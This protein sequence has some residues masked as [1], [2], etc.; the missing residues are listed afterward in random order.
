MD[1][2]EK[3]TI[4]IQEYNELK[5]E[6]KRLKSQVKEVEIISPEQIQIA[7][8]KTLLSVITKIRESL[9]LK[10]IFKLTATE[11]RQLLNADRVAIFQFDANSNYQDGEIVSEDVIKPYKSALSMKVRDT[12]FGQNYA[13]RYQHGRI[14][15][16]TN[17]YEAQLSDCH[18][19]ILLRFQVKANLVIPL[20]Q[21]KHL[22]GLLCIHQCSS[23][24]QWQGTEIAFAKH[25]ALHLCVAIQQAEILR[26]SQ[27]QALEL[28]LTLAQVQEQKQ[29][30][31]KATL[32]EKTLARVIEKIRQSLD[33]EEIFETTAKEVRDLLNVDRVAVIKFMPETLYHQGQVIAENVLEPYNCTLK[34]IVTNEYFGEVHYPDYQIGKIQAI[35]DINT[36]SISDY[37]RDILAQFQ[38]KADLTVPILKGR[39]LWGLLCIHNCGSPRQWQDTEINFSK[40]IANNLGVALLQGDQLEQL[41]QQSNYLITA[42]ER[43]KAI[44]KIINKIRRSLDI[45]TIFQTTTEEVKKL[46]KADRVAIYRFNEDWSGEFIIDS[47]SGDWKSLLEQQKYN[48]E[49]KKNIS[50]CSVKHLENPQ[51]NDTYLQNN[52]GAFTPQDIYRV[53]DDIYQG[54]F[55]N[56]YLEMLELYQVKAYT[57]VAIYHGQK[58]WGLLAAYQ[59]SSNRHWLNNEINFLVQTAANLSVA[60]QQA[61]LLNQAQT[62]SETLQNTLTQQ[63]Q[64]RAEELAE[65]AQRE[66]ALSQVIDK[67]RQ[68]L[69]IDTIFNTA[70]RE[71]RKLLNADRVTVFQFLNDD[72]VEGTFVSENVA[73]N[74]PSVLG[75]KVIDRCFADYNVERYKQG[76]IHAT[77]DIYKEG[78]SDC[79]IELLARFNIKANLIVPIIK[80][81]QLWG[82]LCIHQCS[83][84]RI[85]QEKDIEFVSKIA[86]QLGVALQQVHLLA[87]AQNK[88]LEL[89]S[90]LAD[91]NAIVDNLADG[92]LVTDIQGNITRF[93]PALLEMFKLKQVN[94]LGYKLTT[95]FPLELASLVEKVERNSQEVVTVNVE[96][97]QNRAGQ[98]LATSVIKEAYGNEGDQC[99]GSVILIRDVTME[100]E[101]DRMKTDFLAT[102]SHELRTPLTSV[103]GFASIIEDKLKNVIF[104]ALPMENNPKI[105]KAVKRVG[106]NINIIIS[107]AERLTAL[108][109]DVLDIAK[110][111]AGRIDWTIQKT[112]PQEILEVALCATASLFDNSQVKLIKKIASNLPLIMVDRDRLIQVFINLISN[113]IKFTEKGEIIC[114]I[115]F[116]TEELIMSVKDTG[117]GID[118]KYN[119][120]IFQRFGQ[121]G[122]ILTGKPKGTGLGLPICKQIIEHHG[123]K[124]WME[125][126]LSKGSTFFFTIPLFH[127]P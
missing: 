93:N 47:V 85:W 102:V 4:N 100:R 80:N 14:Q 76:K 43:E 69:D 63:L 41:K 127:N 74:Y 53:C 103:L 20:L 7:Q 88:S 82:L 104:P 122:D 27:Q 86:I 91:L 31:I 54:G 123:G 68:T 71:V 8:Q 87:Q 39:E 24:R 107:E 36:A 57:I 90:T 32:R 111:E 121:G 106:G 115:K 13:L 109:N 73:N 95:Y 113:A 114:E 44:A 15:A 81:E 11:V 50:D 12:C 22:W 46:L 79:H 48:P 35:S 77:T 17:I 30:Q 72:Y 52:Q 26:K 40:Q 61:E 10:T 64:Q 67:I 56:C 18:R 101:V 58:L 37:Y 66:K 83:N 110:M 97:P 9:D 119:Q 89:R 51:F 19:D 45:K 42:V 33:L 112:D 23:P 92:L 28:Q 105:E 99:L 5:Q 2:S 16:L 49:L 38:V 60:I 116:N 98:A 94:L 84:S 70:S 29:A 120:T 55:T 118:P 117:I 21:G 59:N 34:K 124:I 25:I 1:Y 96:L 78:F 62:R 108:I 126:V 75:L 6:L 65:E 3:I 125:S